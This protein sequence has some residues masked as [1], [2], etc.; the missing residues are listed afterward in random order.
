MASSASGD[1]VCN[2]DKNNGTLWQLLRASQRTSGCTTKTLVVI[3][4]T[5]RPIMMQRM[6]A[7]HAAKHDAKQVQNKDRGLLK[8][9][10]AVVLQL[11]G[12]VGC[13]AFVFLPSDSR[14]RCPSCGHPRFNSDKKPNE[15][16]IVCYMHEVCI[17][18]C[19]LFLARSPCCPTQCMHCLLCK[20][21]S[22]G[23]FP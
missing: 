12:C 8:K 13:D 23:T 5:L 14:I 9:A 3:E 21:R 22:V 15:V 11:H 10:N 17:M 18:R 1:D 4:D 6:G 19:V 2:G 16:H 7:K 20:C